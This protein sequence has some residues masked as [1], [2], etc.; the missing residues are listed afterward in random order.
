[1][2]ITDV[3]AASEAPI[4]D[5]TGALFV[6][7]LKALNPDLH[8]RYV[9]YDKEFTDVKKALCETAHEDDLILLLGAG[10]LTNLPDKVC[11]E[12]I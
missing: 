1:M 3:Y 12:R 7:A 2:I 9:A 5:V 10:K 6:R 11:T 4:A 8:V